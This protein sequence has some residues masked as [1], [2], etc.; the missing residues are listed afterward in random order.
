MK[1][2]ELTEEQIEVIYRSL[3]FATFSLNMVGS[4]KAGG[5]LEVEKEELDRIEKLKP[6][7]KYED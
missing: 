4:S 2:F 5:L 7:F 3:D 1:T 6:L